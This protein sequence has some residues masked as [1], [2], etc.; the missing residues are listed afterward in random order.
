MCKIMETFTFEARRFFFL[1]DKRAP[2]RS[3]FDLARLAGNKRFEGISGVSSM[4]FA[5]I[6]GNL[7]ETSRR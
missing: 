1:F 2:R 7:V 4:G 3:D 6:C 5:G